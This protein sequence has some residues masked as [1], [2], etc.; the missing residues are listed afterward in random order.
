[1]ARAKRA[2]ANWKLGKLETYLGFQLRRAQDLSFQAFARRVG[3]ADLKPGKF[4][5]LAVIATN[6][7]INQTAL[8]QATGRDKSTLTPALRDLVERG[9]VQRDP[10]PNDRRA[11]ALT[12]TRA[13]HDYLR[14]LT[15]HVEEH[16]RDLDAIVGKRHKPLLLDLLG[17]IVKALDARQTAG[18]D[19]KPA[20]ARR[21]KIDRPTALQ[22]RQGN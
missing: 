20:A 1:M 17:R 10:V 9:W 11:Y 22:R 5:L 15:Q 12:L 6:P 8:S 7:G 21:A 18:A 2:A 4:A 19:R 14:L 3:Q 13:G 16:D